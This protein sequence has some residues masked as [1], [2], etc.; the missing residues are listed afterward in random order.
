MSDVSSHDVTGSVRET[1][2][3]LDLGEE[4]RAACA[5]AVRLA[6][7]IDVE[8]S[9]RT[10][11]ELAGKLLAVLESLGATPAARKALL[12]GVNQGAEVRQRSTLDELRERR[13]RR[14]HGAETVDTTTP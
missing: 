7:A 6:E 3:E 14:K 10:V 9:G 12:K 11:S 4:D 8:G 13:D 1:L 5:L 2:A